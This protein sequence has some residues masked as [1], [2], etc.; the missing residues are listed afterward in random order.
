MALVMWVVLFS[1]PMGEDGRVSG[2]G[3]M[4]AQLG[5]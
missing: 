4:V 2:D 1:G 3:G 5:H